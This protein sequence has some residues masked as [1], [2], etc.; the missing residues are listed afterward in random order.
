MSSSPDGDGVPTAFIVIVVVSCVVFI[1]ICVAVVLRYIK[2]RKDGVPLSDPFDNFGFVRREI[3]LAV[4]N[5][6]SEHNTSNA[7]AVKV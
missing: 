6:I 1:L 4:D 2:A 7:K 3:R 5:A